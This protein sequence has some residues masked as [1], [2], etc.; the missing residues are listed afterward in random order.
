MHLKRTNIEIDESKLKKAKRIAGIKSTKE[1]VDYALQR[2]IAGSK[3]LKGL[4][5]LQGKVHFDDSYDYKET[6]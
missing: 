6:R 4:F 3:S 2:L 5:D 1:V